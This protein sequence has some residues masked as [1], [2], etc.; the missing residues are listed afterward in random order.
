M[1]RAKRDRIRRRSGV[2]RVPVANVPQSRAR[3]DPGKVTSPA[4][5]A[6]FIPRMAGREFGPAKRS[7]PSEAS[8]NP[9]I[10]RNN[11]VLPAPFGPMT[12]SDWAAASSNERP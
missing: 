9:A 7:S 11:V 2:M 12:P 3:T 1:F 10:T 8:T 5:Y 6:V 4:R